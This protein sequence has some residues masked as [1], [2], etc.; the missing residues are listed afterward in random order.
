[1]SKF[2]RIALIA[3]LNMN[4]VR[5][6]LQKLEQFLRARGAQVIYEEQTAKL[7]DWKVPAVLPVNEFSG[8][9]DLGIVVGGDGSMLSGARKMAPS[10]IPILGINRGRLGFLTD[11]SPD[12]I[13]ERVRLVLDGEYKISRRSLLET[14]IHR[15]RSQI[16]SG[17]AFN[18]VVLHPGMS[19]RMM[20]FELY[21]DGQFVYSQGSD[22]LVVSTPTGSTAYA[23][24]AGG[25]L[26]FPELDAIV[27]VP[28]NP[29]TLSSRPIV[30][31]GD[32]T[33]EIHVAGRNDVHPLV[34]C[35]GH[36]DYI[37]E[38]GDVIRIRKHSDEILL[39]H[40][41]GHDFYSTCRTKLGW[42]SHL[43]ASSKR[44]P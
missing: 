43:G 14:S 24:S 22:G 41:K 42:G 16:G 28:L 39:L 27:V 12:D 5:D 17:T 23:L 9:V 18:D 13:E 15:N 6:S 26:L 4:E 32:S 38:P 7:V 1:M 8:K 3:S 31:K 21:V 33:I 36:N 29:H 30:L 2:N 25:P 11:I 37:T 10:R 20:E 44:R 35:D 40:P 34:T 19:V